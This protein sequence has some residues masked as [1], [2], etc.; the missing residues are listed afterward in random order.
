MGAS[1]EQASREPTQA[2]RGDKILGSI[3]AEII[4][5]MTGIF[6]AEVAVILFIGFFGPKLFGDDDIVEIGLSC[7]AFSL[8]LCVMLRPSVINP[9]GMESALKRSRKTAASV[10]S[11]ML[12]TCSRYAVNRVSMVIPGKWLLYC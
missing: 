2:G 1:V 3:I 12:G 6:M 10:L 8:F 4:K 7:K 9:A 11:C 5:L